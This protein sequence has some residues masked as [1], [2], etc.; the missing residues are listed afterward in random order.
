[1]AETTDEAGTRVE[2]PASG[3][4]A[5]AGNGSG[6]DGAE[7]D[8]GVTEDRLE[9]IAARVVGQFKKDQQVLSFGELVAEVRRDPHRISRG[10][11]EYVRDM[12]DW[13]GTRPVPGTGGRVVPRWNLFD[14]PWSG[15]EGAVRG[16]EEVQASL[17]RFL[18]SFCEKGR[19]DKLLMLHGPNG[20]SKST[21]VEAIMGGLEFYSGEAAGAVYTFTWVFS[22]AFE[23]DR[24]G[25]G[26]G[27][28]KDSPAIKAGSHA[29][30]AP[31][32]I[33]FQMPC[34]L[35][36][37]PLFLIPKEERIR[38]LE[39]AY[40]GRGE[41]VRLSSFMTDGDLCQ[42]CREIYTSLLNAYQGD[43]S[44]VVSH[45][46]VER[47]S[48][49]KRYR[50]SAVTIEPQRNV[51]GATRAL[52]LEKNFQIPPV[53]GHS[54]LFEP[55]GDLI[56]A[57]GGIVEYSDF[58]KRPLEMHKY[59]LTTCEKNSISLPSLMAYL[60]V[61][62]LATSNE[63]HLS[64]F[65][66]DP[67][68]SAFKGR[69]ELICVPYLIEVSKEARIYERHLEPIRVEKHVAPHTAWAAALWAV[70]TRLRRPK[71]KHYSSDLGAVV[72][73]LTPVQKADLYD[74]AGP[75]NDLKEAE[76]R[77]LAG[78]V[79]KIVAEFEDV[80]EE[81]EGMIDAAYEGRRGASPREMMTLLNEAAAFEGS[82]CVS[83]LT[84]LRGMRDLS[85]DRSL[86]DFLRLEADNGYG[87]IE[88]L[89][90]EVE[91]VYL[92]RV[93][94]E[95]NDAIDLVEAKEYRRLFEDY[96]LHVKAFNRGER[97]PNRQTGELEEPNDEL[98][99]K[100]EGVIGVREKPDQFRRSL[101]ERI[102]AW[103]IGHANQPLDY[104]ELFGDI[105]R[106]LK[107]NY[108]KDREVSVEAITR[109]ILRFGT[110]DARDI[111]AEDRP[112]VLRS[113]ARLKVKYGYCVDCAKEVLT[114]VLKNRAALQKG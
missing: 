37:N 14:T 90:E 44:R 84:L 64:A 2:A 29:Y 96:F 18:Q 62:M 79:G 11:F 45:I 74:G 93:V 5:A 33:S 55:Y 1:M 40:Q 34:E 26:G 73:R 59:L 98:M 13:F 66:R 88:R 32:E 15:G 110:E 81:F 107:T 109:N 46:R 113:L 6:A 70:L 20:S 106:A 4:E 67:D 54:N 68:F 10:A 92:E 82:R 69:I 91:R 89:T 63:K 80:E 9:S 35:K 7:A 78:N 41:T 105:L 75:P 104:D 43:W 8:A 83:P 99:S 77:D 3:G 17:Y 48:I 42:K 65:K 87:D 28:R 95:V 52:N 16:Q 72:A 38:L 76:R 19:A 53:L 31:E 51:D 112:T 108:Y 58:F 27:A 71:S 57:N 24:L 30:L 39:D 25:F 103:A 50:R 61:V 101:I 21:I 97:V 102:A 47:L 23:R 85:R 22:D 114:F 100:V 56:D 60:N 86:Y 12:F 94:E 111:K 36:D 49:S